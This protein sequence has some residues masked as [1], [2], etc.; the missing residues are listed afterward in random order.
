MDIDTFVWMCPVPRGMWEDKVWAY[1]TVQMVWREQ[2]HKARGH[3]LPGPLQVKVMHWGY[4]DG[5]SMEE[6]I[7]QGKTPLA[8]FVLVR[9]VGPALTP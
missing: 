3:R 9:V 8:T 5:N 7:L 2:L 6:V 1:S 4:I